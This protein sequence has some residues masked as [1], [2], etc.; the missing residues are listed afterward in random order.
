MFFF[1]LKC[2]TERK[3]NPW[4]VEKIGTSIKAP[5]VATAVSKILCQAAQPSKHACVVPSLSNKNT[6]LGESAGSV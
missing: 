4:M 1:F 2:N 3:T 6:Q 5:S